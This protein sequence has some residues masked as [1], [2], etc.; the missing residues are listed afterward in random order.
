MFGETPFRCY[1]CD[2]L[3]ISSIIGEGYELELKC[4]GCKCEIYIRCKEPIPK[5]AESGSQIDS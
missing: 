2:K 5:E 1:N 4:P 3:L